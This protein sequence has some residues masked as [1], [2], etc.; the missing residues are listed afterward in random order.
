MN[1][2]FPPTI[3]GVANAVVNYAK[4]ITASHGKCVVAT[5]EYPDV[6]DDYPFPVVRYPSLDTTQLTGYR[7]GNP[8]APETIEKLRRMDCNLIHSHCPVASTVLAR[9]LRDASN[10]PDRLHLSHEV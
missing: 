10:I 4:H 3:D 1:D 8:L 6:T 5:P 7:A 9:A 2:S